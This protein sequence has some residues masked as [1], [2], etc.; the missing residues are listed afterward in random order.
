MKTVKPM[1]LSV[2][3]RC[4]EHRGRKLFGV[5]VLA[6]L[7]LEKRPTL[8]LETALWPF[9][10]DALGKDAA[11]EIGMPKSVSEFLVFGSAHVPDGQPVPAIAI[12][13]RLGPVDKTALVFGDRQWKRSKPGEAA[14]FTS[15]P[16]DWSRAFGG[17]AFADN[18]IGKG[19]R[20]ADVDPKQVR[21]LPNFEVP[22]KELRRPTDIV[23]PIGFG[24]VD[25]AWPQRAKR[26]GTYDDRWLRTRFPGLPDDIDW[27]HFNV[28][29]PDQWLD[30][31]IA[32]DE[33]FELRHLHPARPAIEGR[34]PRM[35]ARAFLNRETS[36]APRLEEV[37]LALRTV[38]FFPDRERIVLIWQGSARIADEQAADVVHLMVGADAASTPRSED[39]YL[40]VLDRRLDKEKGAFAALRDSDLTPPGM[41]L[42][43]LTTAEPP[44]DTA[45]NRALARAES[46]CEESRE[47]V[48]SHGL[49]PD[50]HAPV[51]PARDQPPPTRLEDIGDFVDRKEAEATALVAEQKA[52][53]DRQDIALAAVMSEMGHDFALI[54]EER[55]RGQAGPPSF[56]AD[57]ELEKLRAVAED[58]ASGGQRVPELDV[59]LADPDY[60]R[61]LHFAEDQMRQAYRLT[62]H[63]QGAAQRMPDDAAAALK[64]QL[65]ADLSEGRSFAGRDLTGA[66]LSGLD[67]QGADLSGAMLE[68]ANLAGAR[69]E[70][71]RLVD[72]VLAR[73]DLRN[74]VL[75]RA[76]MSGANL[77]GALLAGASIRTAALSGAILAGADLSDAVFAE[78]DLSG[79]DLAGAKFEHTDLSRVRTPDAV[80]DQVDFGGV[81]LR[82]A[83]LTKC[84]FLKCRFNGTDLSGADLSGS[85][86]IAA[87]AAGARFVEARLPRSAFI[88]PADLAGADFSRADLSGASLREARLEG[89]RFESA[90]L[91]E[92]DLSGATAARSFFYMA[93]ARGARFV[94]SNLADAIFASANLMNA[95]LDRAVLN[96]ADFRYANLFQ[97]D[98]SRVK[99]D[100]ATR[101]NGIYGK[102]ARTWPR[103]A[104]DQVRR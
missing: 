82:A 98:L 94:K 22:Y 67:L 57:A 37:E 100:R 80:F 43:V 24:L 29:S 71:C 41:L 86:F 51:I 9:L 58:A 3:T 65:A 56:S 45:L 95:I 77:G 2:L 19:H 20:P 10:A 68:S 55:A 15:M 5:S 49:D 26:I 27:R 46:I 84:V 17:P 21:D 34:L 72:A 89:A 90:V 25:A 83:Q 73:A 6:F 23:A 11:L 53:V 59:Y 52:W 88:A 14:P 12:R 16:L 13:A 79:A 69:L 102:R 66:D 64:V 50:T 28:A 81:V 97:G 62:A 99:V 8:L 48:R 78:S 44:D 92:A 33:A 74:A 104:P 32:A 103:P 31:G 101:W 61:R 7:T 93:D 87:A 70:G 35:S 76:N 47:L 36:G 18:P 39:D 4:Y 38:A 96:G 75:D 42:G 1:Q 85:A 40:A 54:A 30:R 63:H 91:R 60:A